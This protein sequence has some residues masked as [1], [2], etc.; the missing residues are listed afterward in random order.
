MT[1]KRGD[2]APLNLLISEYPSARL[3]SISY[4]LGSRPECCP[5]VYSC[6]PFASSDMTTHAGSSA[7]AS[8]IIFAVS[9]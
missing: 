5:P 1:S 4:C 8:R 3:F 9:G 2:L 6:M 7:L